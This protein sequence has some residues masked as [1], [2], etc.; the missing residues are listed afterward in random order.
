MELSKFATDPSVAPFVGAILEDVDHF[1]TIAANDHAKPNK[2]Q[3]TMEWIRNGLY[4]LT[5]H[6]GTG[7]DAAIAGAGILTAAHAVFPQ[8][9]PVTEGTHA[10]L[11]A[12]K[13]GSSLIHEPLKELHDAHKNKT[14][15]EET[16]IK[17]VHNQ[18]PVI[19]HTEKSVAP[20]PDDIKRGVTST[21]GKVW[22]AAE[23][24]EKTL[25]GEGLM[26]I[27]NP[28]SGV[29][30]LTES[31][32]KRVKSI[33]SGNNGLTGQIFGYSVPI[34]K[35]TEEYKMDENKTPRVLRRY[36]EIF[37]DEKSARYDFGKQ[38]KPIKA[39]EWT[40]PV[41]ERI[42]K[43]QSLYQLPSTT[44]EYADFNSVE[45]KHLETKYGVHID[46]PKYATSY[47]K[48]NN[49]PVASTGPEF[50]HEHG[51]LAVYNQIE[52]SSTDSSHRSEL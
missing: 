20:T 51:P 29:Y 48:W 39:E 28:K 19:L 2:K 7:A 15:I 52:T 35:V 32:V 31:Q 25:Q 37:S 33:A 27:T 26:P 38:M 44:Q 40:N 6:I 42:Y 3:T 30:G 41:T 16:I 17:S 49:E 13:A 10:L 4:E 46:N 8:I 22:L 18:Q 45:A 14:M 23:G 43:R 5:G 21:A 47:A 12:I 24:L 9:A 50:Y 11:H 34:R 36:D 1:G